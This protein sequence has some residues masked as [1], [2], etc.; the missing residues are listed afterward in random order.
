MEWDQVC[1]G[2][3]A[4][5][6]GCHSEQGYLVQG[7]SMP[8]SFASLQYLSFRVNAAALGCLCL[9]KIPF[10][11]PTTRVIPVDTSGINK[12]LV[13]HRSAK[14][15]ELCV[16]PLCRLIKVWRDSFCWSSK[17]QNQESWVI[18]TGTSSYKWAKITLSLGVVSPGDKRLPHTVW[19]PQLHLL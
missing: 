14:T 11:F 7:G 9:L 16:R 10:L 15:E 17:S 1:A 8:V 6:G 3:G 2:L 4:P 12:N 13:M 19:R 5:T 18:A